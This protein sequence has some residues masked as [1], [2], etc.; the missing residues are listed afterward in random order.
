MSLL[1]SIFSKSEIIDINHAWFF[2]NRHQISQ[3]MTILGPVDQRPVFGRPASQLVN[4]AT[5]RPLIQHCR[6][7]LI[8]LEAT[9]ATLP[10]AERSGDFAL[11]HPYKKM[12]YDKGHRV[13]F[14]NTLESIRKN[15]P[16]C[17]SEKG[18]LS[19]SSCQ[20]QSSRRMHAYDIHE[21]I[22]PYM[23]WTYTVL[24]CKMQC[25][26][27]HYHFLTHIAMPYKAPKNVKL[28]FY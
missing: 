1:G 3:Q 19:A 2:M 4:L 17:P 18:F 13:K 20:S 25:N 5:S 15:S 22:G 8:E 21:Y 28:Q 23:T 10:L 26:A 12:K 14:N 11:P 6:K 24:Q 27:M 7:L 9:A 16:L